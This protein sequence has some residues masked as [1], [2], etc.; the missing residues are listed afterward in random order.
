MKTTYTPFISDEGKERI[1]E[2]VDQPDG[3][4]EEV[5]TIPSSDSLTYSN[6]FYVKCSAVFID[7]RGSSQ[8]P[9]KHTR[10]VLGKV[11]RAYIS[12][13][14]AVLNGSE[15]CREIFIAGDCVSGMFDT[16]YKTDIDAAFE[17]AARL[18]SVIDVLNWL[19]EGKGYTT[20]RCGI[21]LAWGRA[22]MLKAGFKGSG[23]NDIVWMGDVVNH[24]SN[25]CHDGNRGS[26]KM[27]QISTDF[28]NN[29]KE[30]YQKMADA[31]R[32]DDFFLGDVTHYETNVINSAMDKWLEEQ[33]AEQARKA[34]MLRS[35]LR[36][37]SLS[38][39][40]ADFLNP[41]R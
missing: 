12:E 8:L 19:F 30:D 18:H 27:I 5:D 14:V 16:P 20:I 32:E 26:R 13:C 4:F 1:K 35:A 38:Q 39:S 21:G 3:Q 15:K 2:I 36:G 34:E 41:R 11:Y 7:I 28:Y 29:M 17:A 6:G 10:P 37:D 40:L 22:L 25:L 31:V 9:E 33:K 24:A 23:I